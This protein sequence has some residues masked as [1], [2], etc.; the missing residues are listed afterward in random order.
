MCK[1]STGFRFC[2][3]VLESEDVICCGVF[4]QLQYPPESTYAC[5][6]QQQQQQQAEDAYYQQQ[7]PRDAYEW[8]R[9][10][11]YLQ[12]STMSSEPLPFLSLSPP[13]GHDE[14]LAD[15]VMRT[16]ILLPEA[17]S[18]AS[19]ESDENVTVAL[20]IGPP[21]SDDMSSMRSAESERSVYD[22][23]SL[24]ERE[25]LQRGRGRLPEGQYWIPTPAQILVGPTQF[26]CPVCNKTFNRYN[27]M[28]VRPCPPLLLISP[29]DPEILHSPCCSQLN[30]YQ[31]HEYLST[32]HVSTVVFQSNQPQRLTRIHITLFSLK[33]ISLLTDQKPGFF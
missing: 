29:S 25:R 12:N 13:T 18:H 3:L 24:A 27:N 14:Y 30:P 7:Q 9:Q 23:L 10:R 21:S 8:Q 32:V 28:Q 31:A 33:F 5:S 15:T 4:V 22:S 11:A 26:S 20:H 2:F 19:E 16:A 17:S 1:V 6:S